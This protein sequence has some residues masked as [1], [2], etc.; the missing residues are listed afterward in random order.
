MPLFAA[1]T[2]YRT[3]I[4][5]DKTELVLYSQIEVFCRKCK[6]ER[7]MF[8]LE[9]RSACSLPITDIVYIKEGGV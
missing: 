4:R 6:L 5:E 7:S 9:L 2:L 8:R 3:L 1:T